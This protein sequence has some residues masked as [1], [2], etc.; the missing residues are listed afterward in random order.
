MAIKDELWWIE[1][2]SDAGCWI[3]C[4]TEESVLYFHYV[5]CRLRL[6]AEMTAV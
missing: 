3:A 5:L 6:H 1:R 4:T 2:E